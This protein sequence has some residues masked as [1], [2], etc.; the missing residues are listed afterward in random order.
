[1]KPLHPALIVA[2]LLSLSG[3]LP[4]SI[5]AQTQQEQGASMSSNSQAT[6]I[7]RFYEEALNQ[8]RLD[9]LPEL[10]TSNVVNHAFDGTPQTGIPALEQGIR[11]TQHLFTGQ[12]FT[13]DDVV[14]NGDKAAARWTMTANNTVPIGGLAPT[15]K[16]ITEHAVV[17]YRFEDGKIAEIWLQI[18]R[19]GVLQQVGAQIPGVP[20]P[21]PPAAA[22]R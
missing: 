14:V 11:R 10:V 22:A 19:L 13:I 16:Q 15:G 2:T 12:H 7:H 17:F 5:N 9:L 6:V 18:D 8:N 1:M 20:A 4:P 3:A 21:Q